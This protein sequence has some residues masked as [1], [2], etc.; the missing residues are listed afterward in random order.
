MPAHFV[1]FPGVFLD[2]LPIYFYPYCLK[3]KQGNEIIGRKTIYE[4]YL[5]CARMS[6]WLKSGAQMD[7]NFM[8]LFLSAG[9]VQGS[10]NGSLHR[11]SG[12]T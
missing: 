12:K 8:L 3:K 5:K 2:E 7:G 11:F 4:S 6:D 10:W 9:N 1:Y